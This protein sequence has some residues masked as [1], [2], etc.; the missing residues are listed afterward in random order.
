MKK[1]KF[2][3][4]MLA[5]C[6]A[7]PVLAMAMSQSEWNQ[8]CRAKLSGSTTI[9][10]I[11]WSS[12]L[13]T[14]TDVPV[15]ES[16]SLP[17]G[18]Y[19]KV[20]E[21]DEG[22]N[23]NQIGYLSGENEAFAW[24]R[25][26]SF[27]SAVAFVEIDDGTTIDVPE[28]LL[29]NQSALFSY[30]SQQMPGYTFSAI[31]GSSKIHKSKGGSGAS[32]ENGGKS[33]WQQLQESSKRSAAEI[34]VNPDELKMALIYAP[35]T[36][37][38]SLRQKASSKGKVIRKLSDGVIVHVVSEEGNF[39]QVLYEDLLG[40]VLTDALEFP[41]PEQLPLGA[42]MVSY[43]GTATGRQNVP[44]HADGAKKSRTVTKWRSGA[45]VV[46]WSMTED[47]AYYEVESEGSR[48]WVEAKFLT[49]NELYEYPEEEE[50]QEEVPQEEEPQTDTDTEEA[51]S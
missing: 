16:G 12:L 45:E 10:T 34:G 30:L 51:S 21:Y 33:E 7:M 19:I 14:E 26:G 50:P 27:T 4:L 23:M 15:K 47:G 5:A 28:A 38:A 37:E 42:G 11:D 46:I 18:T 1:I 49:V 29:Q 24:I 2:F 44:M 31:E 25:S 43:S 17:G 9:Y 39:C 8:Q 20:Y 32:G 3:I 35:R 13:A 48:L 36:G 6:V 22:I 40:Y 41:D